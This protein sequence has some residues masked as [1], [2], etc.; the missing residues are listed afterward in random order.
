MNIKLPFGMQQ[1]KLV[2]IMSVESGLACNCFCPS[3]GKQLIA[4]KGNINEH[5][6]AHY[7][8]EDC[9]RGVETALH[10][11]TKDILINNTSI[12]LPPVYFD[13]RILHPDTIVQ[14]NNVLLEK[15]LNNII[16]DIIIHV[17]GKPLLIEISVTHMVD[18]SKKQKIFLSG[19]SAIEIDVKNLFNP[20]YKIFG[21]KDFEKRLIEDVNGK[22]WIN[23]VKLNDF[24]EKMK[25]NSIHRN[26][27]TL[28]SPF[29]LT[30]VNDCPLNKKVWQGGSFKGKIYA[31][32][33]EDCS[34]CKYG[35]I[36][37]IKDSKVV[38]CFGHYQPEIDKIITNYLKKPKIEDM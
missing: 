31:N 30:F 23:N 35:D 7:H 28:G 24:I 22:R 13:N 6:F 19:Y 20:L 14:Y 29:Y 17:K 38:N 34:G 33:Y 11:K 16:P 21:F 25:S 4:K 9:N 1:G 2:D 12:V 32:V 10:I 8:S 18:W 15:R 27:N 3:C 5:H 37:E 36:S 26:V